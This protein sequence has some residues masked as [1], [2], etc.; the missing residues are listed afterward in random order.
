[1][2]KLLSILATVILTSTA[3]LS[4]I[5]T[6]PI[7]NTFKKNINKTNNKTI[8]NFQK[9]DDNKDIDWNNI[10]KLINNT[11][12]NPN[13]SC[14]SDSGLT[15]P[16]LTDSQKQIA[17]TKSFEYL[18]AIKPKNFQNSQQ[19]ND[20]LSTNLANFKTYYDNPV[21]E[22]KNFQE[23]IIMQYF[24]NKKLDLNLDGSNTYQDVIKEVTSKIT[25]ECSNNQQVK[26]TL[27]VEKQETK[28]LFDDSSIDSILSF[29]N[30]R[31]AIAVN[32]QFNQD[33]IKTYNIQLTN[34][35]LNQPQDQKWLIEAIT[36]YFSQ[37]NPE[38]LDLKLSDTHQTAFDKILLKIKS[39]FNNYDQQIKLAL[40]NT[41]AANEN[42]YNDDIINNVVNENASI[43]I[44]INAPNFSKN[45][46]LYLV[47]NFDFLQINELIAQV[48]LTNKSP[49]N[50][51]Q[52]LGLST[53]NTYQDVI[54][55]L[56]ARLTRLMPDI[57]ISTY[58]TDEQ[59]ATTQ[60][61]TQYRP[62]QETK[63]YQVK[64]GFQIQDLQTKAMISLGTTTL[65]LNNVQIGKG[66]QAIQKAYQDLMN[67]V[68]EITLAQNIVDAT[69]IAIGILSAGFWAAAIPTSGATI[70]WAI[71][72][73][74]VAGILGS[75]SAAISVALT[76]YTH[77]YHNLWQG[78][79]FILDITR[80]G[81]WLGLIIYTIVVGANTAL[82][83][84]S[85]ATLGVGLTAALA[86]YNIFEWISYY[87]ETHNN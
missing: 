29:V 83:D 11:I 27:Q 80:L 61:T 15:L 46:S 48:F 82:V 74:V 52:N 6:N 16:V 64:V 56:N 71:G 38:K 73:D 86:L 5:T 12:D 50:C 32:V 45:L 44:N 37:D 9:T 67:L 51:A 54:N 35:H 36:S 34:I 63:Y 26:I 14:I 2:K 79:I 60:L 22:I 85:W 72:C 49:A 33:K 77:K 30:N 17:K 8:N 18:N 28:T 1:M 76:I 39:R 59:T 21:K 47:F 78:A 55:K 58:L 41:D 69:A 84:T 87:N 24:A 31:I 40:A 57:K 10:E 81:L 42:F 3:T 66:A 25:D 4:V 65:Y 62:D 68:N 19:V 23:K 20:Y 53:D 43:D 7:A 13:H 75:A 70:N